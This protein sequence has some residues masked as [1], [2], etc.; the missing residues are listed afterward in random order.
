MYQQLSIFDFVNEKT[1]EKPKIK[2]LSV[3]DYIGRLVIGEVRKSRITKVEGNDEYFFYRTDL[4]CFYKT[5]RT[6]FEQ[7]E[8]EAKEIRRQ[9]KTIE[10]DC[11]D[12]FL[13]VKY[14]PRNCSSYAMV[15]IYND[16]LF[17]EKEFT[18]Q[19]LEKPKNLEKEYKKKCFEITEE[20]KY[21]VL[22]K[23]I[24]TRRLYWSRHGFYADA[25]YVKN[26]G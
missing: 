8:K 6:D 2:R 26:N 4:G 11:F 22:D 24:P 14:Q 19:F 21:E 20:R 25:E 1:E 17:W 10:I 13:A 7:M 3:G 16:M 5:D 15:G 23:P 18:Y 9:Y 12:K